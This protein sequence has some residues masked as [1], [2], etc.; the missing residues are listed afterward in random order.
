[1]PT[2]FNPVLAQVASL[3]LGSIGPIDGGRTDRKASGRIGPLPHSNIAIIGAPSVTPI[4]TPHCSS[5]MSV[6]LARNV[7]ITLA[8]GSCEYA[9]TRIGQAAS[10]APTGP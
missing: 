3:S 8:A 5:V 2:H 7:R 1:M 10:L 4:S 9:Q 6:V